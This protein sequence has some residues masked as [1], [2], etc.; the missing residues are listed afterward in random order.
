[1]AAFIASLLMIFFA[2]VGDKTQFL[3]LALASRY[4]IG[5]VLAGIFIATLLLNAAAVGAGGFLVAV[6]PFKL[7]SLVASLS[8]ILFGVLSLRNNGAGSENPKESGLGP[9]AAVVS[10][11]FLAEF[12]DKTQLAALSLSVEYKSFFGVLAGATAGMFLA[13]AAGILAGG[14]L[15]KC[16]PESIV[17]RLAALIFILFGLWGL[18]KL[19]MAKT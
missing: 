7:L 19:Y 17:K 13:D 18:W 6:I 8:F 16:L 3:A 4:S 5:K 1:M 12:G 9:V 2:E 15:K 10:A 11:F 14:A